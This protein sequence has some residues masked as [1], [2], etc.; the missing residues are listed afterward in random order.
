MNSLLLLHVNS[1]LL[2][3]VNSLLLHVNSLLVHVKSLLLVHVK[4]LLLVHVKSLLLLLHVNLGGD[5][6][7]RLATKDLLV[8][9]WM[10]L[11]QNA[12]DFGVVVRL[13][14]VVP[15]SLRVGLLLK[16][17]HHL[18]R[19]DG[20]V[21]PTLDV[22][23]HGI[24]DLLVAL[25]VLL[26][27]G[28][29]QPVR[30]EKL[31]KLAWLHATKSRNLKKRKHGGRHFLGRVP[32][33]RKYERREGLDIN[34]DQAVPLLQLLLFLPGGKK[35]NR[36]K[37][38]KY[39]NRRSAEEAEAEEGKR[40]RKRKKPVLSFLFPFLRLFA[41][42]TF[43]PPRLPYLGLQLAFLKCDDNIVVLVTGRGRSRRL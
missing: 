30:L 34:R 20:V 37:K 22:L 40:R 17:F 7:E 2:L 43:I 18:H 19:S 15:P 6:V 27:L 14:Q 31:G 16:P 9:G 23:E 26:D 10:M 13:G 42:S 38:R 5:D 11:A 36:K 39:R 4:S 28:L 33:A 41:F 29:G 35:K 32:L 25:C 1:L 21:A 8:C 12:P 24:P 3:H